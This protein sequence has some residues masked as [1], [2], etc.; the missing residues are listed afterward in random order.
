MF[1]IRKAAP[2][3]LSVIVK[4]RIVMFQT[5]IKES[6]DREARRLG[7]LKAGKLESWEA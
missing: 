1:H 7:S 3:D 6:Y 5:F 2:K 4:Y